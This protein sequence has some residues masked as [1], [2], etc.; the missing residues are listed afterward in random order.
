MVKKAIA[1]LKNKRASDKLGWRAEWL[2]EGGEEIAKSLSILFNRI[3]REQRTLVQWRQTTI[4]SIYKG[5]N[6][7]NI[8]ESQRGI[9]LVN[10]ISKVYELVKIVQNEK[11]IS[12]MSEMQAAGGK[13]RS[14]MDNLIIMNTIIENQRAQKLNTY[15]FF[16]DAVKC[17]DKLWLKDCLLEI[18][19][20]G[21]DPNTLKILYEMSKE[22]D[23]IIKTPVGNT[24]NI[25]VKEVVKQGTIFGPIM[26][27]AEISTVNSSG[28]EVK[29]IYGKINIGMPVSMDDIA[30]AGKAE[31][32][33]KGINNCARMEKENKISFGLKKT[34]YMIVKTERE[35]EEIN[36]AVKAG[37]IQRTDKCK[38]LGI[39]ISADG[40]VTEHIKEL[41]TRCD[42]IN[43]EI[44]AI[45]AKT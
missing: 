44:C 9:Y 2:K 40:Q 10:I 25:H 4:K 17:F 38:Y 36:E 13:E 12:K 33:R 37:R 23:V 32:I 34:K 27:C 3:E 7:A 29:Y 22:T 16:A 14:A 5:G 8:S 30:T 26:C 24:D 15:M 31:H 43:R 41:N 1:K 42:I 18:Y 19:N 45:R 21:Y 39:T 28:E 11:N 20:L 6:K 35:E